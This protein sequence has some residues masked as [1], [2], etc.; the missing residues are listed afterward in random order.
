MEGRKAIIVTIGDELLM[1]QVVDTNS[2]WIAQQLELSGIQTIRRW[3]IPDNDAV[4][5][6]TLADVIALADYSI[7]TGGLGPTNDDLTKN[8]MAHYFGSK[9]VRNEKVY[10]H[11]LKIFSDRKRTLTQGNEDQALVP[12][13]CTVL[14][15]SIGTAPGMW[16]EKN[17]KVVISLPGVPYEMKAI[18][19]QE[20]LPRIR[21]NGSGFF[22]Q[23]RHFLLMNVS[24]TD[25]AQKIKSIENALP[26]RIKLAYLPG[27]GGLRLR[28]TGSGENEEQL[29]KEID[30]LAFEI[31]N[32]L[33]NLIAAKEDIPI[34]E[35]VGRL[36][37][38]NQLKLGLAESCTGGLIAHKITNI[39]GSSAYFNGAIISYDNQVKKDLLN[40]SGEVLQV[41]G[42]VSEGT[43]CQMAA[44]ARKSLKVDIALSISGILGPGGGSDK[45]PTGTVWMAIADVHQT[46]A[47]LFHFYY[48]RLLNKERAANTALEWLRKWILNS[49]TVA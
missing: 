11:I 4:I 19:E 38:E 43:V 27:F 28:L 7:F 13:N 23:H 48:D 37:L 35:V 39:P 24:E 40:V 17:E 2:S 32:T 46:E 3:A 30:H 16:F 44:A 8:A 5:Q 36:L 20:V 9:L 1:G 33:G 10:L 45:K 26:E 41:H 49:R 25:I 12:D 29:R 42:A 22:R 34:E 18:F 6:Q 31:E 47:K 14:Y 21:Q 15:N